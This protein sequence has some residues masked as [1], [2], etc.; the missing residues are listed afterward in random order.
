MQGSNRTCGWALRL[1]NMRSEVKLMQ[2]RGSEVINIQDE[3][4]SQAK[5][6]E[7]IGF[8]L[9]NNNKVGT[10]MW[11]TNWQET[12]HYVASH[13]LHEPEVCTTSLFPVICLVF[14]ALRTN[15]R[16][17]IQCNTL[18][19]CYSDLLKNSILSE[20]SFVAVQYKQPIWQKQK[21]QCQLSPKYKRKKEFCIFMPHFPHIAFLSDAH[22]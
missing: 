14:G 9:T 1:R 2:Q 3:A 19:S 20:T 17:R 7:K 22:T 16:G 21:L 12:G 6:T 5:S 8:N 4:N 11:I 10:E 13:F 18:Q 15:G